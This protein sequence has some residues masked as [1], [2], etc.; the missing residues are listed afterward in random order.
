M[1]DLTSSSAYEL[2]SLARSLVEVEG[3]APTL[4]KIVD[5]AVELVPCQW[6]AIAVSPHLKDHPA[7]HSTASDEE[8][9]AAVA[10]IAGQAGES[11]GISAFTNGGIVHCPDLVL[12]ARFAE[13][14]EGMLRETMVRSVL[15]IAIRVHD[16]IVGV[17]TMYADEP[18][19]FDGDVLDR[20]RLLV[21]HAALAIAAE[22]SDDRAQNLEIA[23]AHSRT[24]GA[25][26]GI[27]TERYRI[28]PAHAFERLRHASQQGNRKVSAIA[29][30]LVETGTLAGALGDVLRTP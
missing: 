11:P 7:R 1:T 21:Q 18:H 16:T 23:L 22:L 26:I 14:R 27:L 17:L 10:R 30:E 6:A 19:A 20:A 13:Y 2:A 24:I 12:D 28:P 15:S 25:A 8:F 3:F 5:N 9:G 4:R 29:V